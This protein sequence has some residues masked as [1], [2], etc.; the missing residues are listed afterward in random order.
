[1]EQVKKTGTKKR[2]TVK[3]EVKRGN[4]LALI[5]GCFKGKISYDEAMFNFEK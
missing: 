2:D 4:K 3:K 5:F 1:M